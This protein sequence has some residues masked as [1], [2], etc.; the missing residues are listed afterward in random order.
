MIR[1]TK[2]IRSRRGTT[3]AEFGPTLMLAFAVIVFPMMAFGQIFLRYIFLLNANEMAAE[4]AAKSENFLTD[5]QQ[6]VNGNTQFSLS[7]V[8]KAQAVAQMGCQGIG[9]GSVQWQNTNVYIYSCP[10][11][12]TTLTSPGANTPLA[13]A[14]NPT[15]NTYNCVV[16]TNALLQPMFPGA[17][18][19]VGSIPGF[20]APIPCTIQSSRYFENTANLND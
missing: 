4:Q 11:G 8:H 7:A 20:N 6:V 3:I 9:N 17:R 18:G 13:A 1:T 19:M 5:A 2:N 12:S 10:L 16:I 14:A 15:A